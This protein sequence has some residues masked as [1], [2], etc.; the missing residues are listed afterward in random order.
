MGWRKSGIGRADGKHGLYEFPQTHVA[1]TAARLRRQEANPL[2][3]I[4]IVDTPALEFA[5]RNHFDAGLRC[6]VHVEKAYS[7]F[8]GF[9]PYAR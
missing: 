8:Q 2:L 1:Y 4:G 3:R 5:R 9:A 7:W 6:I